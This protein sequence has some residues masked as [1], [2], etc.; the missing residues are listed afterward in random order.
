MALRFRLRPLAAEFGFE[1]RSV[2]TRFVMDKGTLEQF[3]LPV[4]QFF[5]VSIIP[6][7]SHAYPSITYAIV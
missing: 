6:A 1:S 5:P 3:F 7:M 2:H 4:F